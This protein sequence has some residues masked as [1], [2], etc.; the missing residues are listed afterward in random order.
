MLKHLCQRNRSCSA[1]S[2]AYQTQPTRSP[3]DSCVPSKSV[4]GSRHKV[5]APG[6]R[7]SF[8]RNPGSLLSDPS[9]AGTLEGHHGQVQ[10]G[11]WRG[12]FQPCRG[13]GPALEPLRQAICLRS[14]SPGSWGIREM[15]C[16]VLSLMLMC[17]PDQLLG[18]REKT[19]RTVS[20]EEPPVTDFGKLCLLKTL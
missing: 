8:T 10:T 14:S 15:G 6:P 7:L 9:G 18:R 2:H 13:S 11:F 20:N 3:L 12:E 5:A 4:A 1:P 16:C 19:P 17:R